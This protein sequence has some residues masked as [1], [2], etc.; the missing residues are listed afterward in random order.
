VEVHFNLLWT[1]V[2][3]PL[4]KE[5]FFIPNLDFAAILHLYYTYEKV[6]LPLPFRVY[7]QLGLCKRARVQD[8]FG[9][10]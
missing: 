1:V 3:R 6:S 7:L 8:F 9:A 10:F 4:T 5:Y 2:R